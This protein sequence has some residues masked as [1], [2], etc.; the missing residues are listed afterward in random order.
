MLVF[1][2]H[3]SLIS[4]NLKLF[5]IFSL[6]FM[7]LTFVFEELRPIILQNSSLHFCLIFPCGQI[8]VIHF[9]QKYYR[10]NLL[11]L[12]SCIR[13]HVLLICLVIDSNNYHHL[14]NVAARFFHCKVIL[15]FR[16][17][18]YLVGRYCEA[19]NVYSSY[20]SKNFFVCVFLVFIDK[21]S[22]LIRVFCMYG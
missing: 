18:K 5:S 22:K 10:N 13:R 7:T 21:I 2:Y 3:G 6:Y 14:A 20:L 16:T 19:M 11:F 4:Y 1:S 12:V 9:W 8:Q 17:S 15:S